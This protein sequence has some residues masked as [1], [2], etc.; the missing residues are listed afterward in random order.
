MLIEQYYKWKNRLL[1]TEIWH[2]KIEFFKTNPTD[3]QIEI[4]D[5][6]LSRKSNLFLI[7]SLILFFLGLGLGLWF[8]VMSLIY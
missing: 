7:G 8:A 6:Y 1:T 5:R 3:E 2:E 4:L